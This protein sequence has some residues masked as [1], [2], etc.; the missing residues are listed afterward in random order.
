MVNRNKANQIK[1]FFLKRKEK[2]RIRYINSFMQ[3][4]LPRGQIIVLRMVEY[5]KG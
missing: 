5:Y 1:F 2:K 3:F 4:L